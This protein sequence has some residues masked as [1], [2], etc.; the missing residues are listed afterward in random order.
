M[1]LSVLTA[2]TNMTPTHIM[3]WP[4]H[5]TR[6][7]ENPNWFV[8]IV[9]WW[10]RIPPYP[11]WQIW[12][13]LPRTVSGKNQS[14]DQEMMCWMH[15]SEFNWIL[16][17]KRQGQGNAGNERKRNN[18]CHYSLR[19]DA[20]IDLINRWLHYLS[21]Q[22]FFDLPVLSDVTAKANILTVRMWFR[23]STGALLHQWIFPDVW[24]TWT[25]FD[26]QH[27]CRL[28]CRWMSVSVGSDV[29]YLVLW[30]S[31]G[32]VVVQIFRCGTSAGTLIF[33]F[34]YS[35][36]MSIFYRI[37]VA[38]ELTLQYWCKSANSEKVLPLNDGLFS[39]KIQS[40]IV[41]L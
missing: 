37:D 32:S 26:V 20:S 18:H 30:F 19:D 4:M 8:S 28:N 7:T 35:L 29:A 17:W 25:W 24:Y 23:C 10:Y 22:L 41:H 40:I 11:H 21:H 1:V 38:I 39:I 27:F 6:I 2:T 16:N 36:H 34:A 3:H 12:N 13:T 9:V 31:S 5:S 15:W 33:A 14:H